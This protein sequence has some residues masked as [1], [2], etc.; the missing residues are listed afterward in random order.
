MKRRNFIKSLG[1]GF[2]SLMIPISFLT[3]AA[4]TTLYRIEI[5]CNDTMVACWN[6][7]LSRKEMNMLTKGVGK[8]HYLIWTENGQEGGFPIIAGGMK[9]L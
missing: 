6:R 3:P 5:D 1:V 4:A 9:C 2:L 7:R 8:G